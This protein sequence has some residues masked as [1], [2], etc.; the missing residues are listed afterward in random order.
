MIAQRI[1]RLVTRRALWVVVSMFIVTAIL[2]HA[3]FTQLSLKVVLEAMLPVQH[4]NVQLIGRFGA[5]FG[6]A[7]TTLIMVENTKGS[8]YSEAYLEAYKRIA[9]QIYYYP[10]V[11]RPLVQA[12]TLRKTKAVVG[13]AGR[14]DIN[15]IAWP[16]LPSTEAQ[17]TAF[18]AAVK[19]QY[20]GTL[21]SDDERA[22]M[23]VADFADDTDYAA[24]VSF[25]EEIGAK[26][27]GAGIVVRMVGRPV[28]LG[29]IDQNL[30]ATIGL[31]AV[32]LVFSGL[33]LWFYFR[34]WMGVLVPM[35][36]AAIGTVW[37]T[38]AM[39]LVGYNLDPLL[40]ILP[41]FV[42]AIVLSHCVQFMSRVFERLQTGMAMQ[43]AVAGGLAQV[44]VPSLTA[45]VAAAGGFFVL[46]LIGIPT[47]QILG[48]ICGAWLLAIAPALMLTAAVLCLMPRPRKFRARTTWAE[49]MWRF[50]RFDRYPAVVLAVTVGLLGAGYFGAQK[51]VIGDAIGSPILWPDARYNQDN[52]VING[53]FAAVGTDTMYVYVDGPPKTMVEPAVYRGLEELDRHVW[54]RVPQ[55]RMG[56][57]LVPMIKAV[58][59]VLYEGDPSYAFIPNSPEEVGFNI[60]LLSSRG[61]PGDF[62]A[63]TNDQWE[64]GNMAIPLDDKTGATVDVA[65]STAR[66]FIARMDP[67]PNGAKL[68]AAGGQVGI[69]EAIND[70]IKDTKDIILIAIVAFIMA[71]VLIAFR[72]VT[73]AAVLCC[74]LLTS[75]YL[76]DTFMWLMGI[77]LNINTLPLAALGVGLGVDYGI[78]ILHRVKEALAEGHSYEEAVRESLRM[79]GNA[80]MITAITMI[81]PVMPWAFFSALKF[82][83]EMGVLHAV[84]LFF[85]MM[86]ALIFVPCVVLLFRPAALRQGHGRPVLRGREAALGE[87]A[88]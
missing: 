39:A 70:E 69:A 62:S 5:Q 19:A 84:V 2:A 22:A 56:L 37:G 32:S 59:K 61:E 10:T 11:N 65:T 1:A 4:Q 47:L 86:A 48:I 24:L 23:V 78:Y 7:N 81:A 41:V 31:I 57:S 35:L 21:V 43:E 83:A 13:S 75:T 28:L 38:G 51:V 79:A 54:R 68:L 58:N 87:G 49:T 73:V 76:T 29:T 9:D 67:L 33:I 52:A 25:I 8:I 64:I 80:V 26:E 53:R 44:F 40:I 42:F 55:A 14:I 34:S 17:W 85:N 36:T 50:A 46:L 88:E 12:L 20:R 45:I 18:E 30:N 15:A 72:S 77:G 6:G 71:S 27:A 66:D 16:N 82:Q 3:S 63:I 60:Y 74:A